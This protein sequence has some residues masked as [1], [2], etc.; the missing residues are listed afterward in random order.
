MQECE[1]PPKD[2]HT[3]HAAIR[4]R[5]GA[6]F[7]I[8]GGQTWTPKVC[9]IMAFMAVIGGLGPLFYILLGFRYCHHLSS[10]DSVFRVLGFRV[11]GF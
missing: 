11:L 3:G 4:A 9:K 5:S 8:F 6:A 2:S 7:F 1:Y 10:I